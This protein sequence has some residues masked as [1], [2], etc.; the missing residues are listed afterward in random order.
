MYGH[1]SIKWTPIENTLN[2]SQILSTIGHTRDS[3]DKIR[4][5][6]FTM[7]VASPHLGDVPAVRGGG[8]DSRLVVD[9]GATG[10]PRASR[11]LIELLVNDHWCELMLNVE[12]F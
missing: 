10:L 3:V 5:L 9:R 6:V 1:G 4:E 8:R 12:E 7:Y 2:V 11:R